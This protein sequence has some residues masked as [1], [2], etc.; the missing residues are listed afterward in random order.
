MSKEGEQ[1][2]DEIEWILAKTKVEHRTSEELVAAKVDE[3]SVR[4]ACTQRNIPF[5]QYKTTREACITGL[6]K[7]LGSNPVFND[8]LD[9]VA[10]THL[11]RDDIRVGFQDK[12][13]L[14]SGT[15]GGYYQRVEISLYKKLL[16]IWN[17]IYDTEFVGG[18]VEM[19]SNISRSTKGTLIHEFGHFVMDSLYK[20]ESGSEP[21]KDN[22][23]ERRAI[24]TQAMKQTMLNLHKHY[25]PDKEI[26]ADASLKEISVSLSSALQG[27]TI[28]PAE[29]SIVDIVTTR[30]FEH[31]I[32]R[33]AVYDAEFVVRLPQILAQHYTDGAT[34]E[35]HL[36]KCFEPFSNYWKDYI[37]PD[38]RKFI[39]TH[40]KK[41]LLTEDRFYEENPLARSGEH[42]LLNSKDL[43]AE[44]QALA[45]QIKTNDKAIKDG[46]YVAKAGE[47]L[48]IRVLRA[49][50][51]SA[52]THQQEKIFDKVLSEITEK[53]F[54]G[55]A[56]VLATELGQTQMAEKLL[57]HIT[58]QYYNTDNIKHQ[59]LQ[60]H[61]D[62]NNVA[63]FKATLS[64]FIEDA[65]P[66]PLNNLAEFVIK[67][68][69]MTEIDTISSSKNLHPKENWVKKL[70][71]K[72]VSNM[73]DYCIK[74]DNIKLFTQ[75]F[76]SLMSSISDHSAYIEI[77]RCL[78]KALSKESLE[79][80][81]TLL[82]ELFT[83]EDYK[84]KSI[85]AYH[86]PEI[87]SLSNI[88]KFNEVVA[89]LHQLLKD[90]PSIKED[91]E[92]SLPAARVVAP[93][94][95][96]I[97]QPQAEQLPPVKIKFPEV[98]LKLNLGNSIPVFSS[99]S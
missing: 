15:A 48:D 66:P 50:L 46:T 78:S 61:I 17:G 29:R 72:N 4:E 9:V 53:Q 2:K 30:L 49:A 63:G 73:I 81:R 65:P 56:L 51:T 44:E 83:Q 62:S 86:I 16:N 35:P 52:I 40:P 34:P 11:S 7:E 82:Q 67:N 5:E 6:M 37:T 88:N 96:S 79:I 28:S 22:D 8:M 70:G 23:N 25:A 45:N 98:P 74:T 26:S 33:E 10:L 55:P 12:D 38:M 90:K 89:G 13:S 41:H 99:S 21:Y 76:P 31:S 64:L 92:I 18:N 20:S 91:L 84:I 69:L 24:F 36:M 97:E 1:P 47:K 80:T 57:P 32:Y 42:Y 58:D 27:K 95:I 60:Q 3:A 75:L 77:S 94:V 43:S 71:Y 68:N 93:P 19:A 14:L 54:L 59:I 87:N 85:L 39:D